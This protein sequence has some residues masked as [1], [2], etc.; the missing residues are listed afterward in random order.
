[1]DRP[2]LTRESRCFVILTGGVLEQ[3]IENRAE[4]IAAGRSATEIAPEDVVRAANEFFEERL[5]DLP[6]L[7]EQAIDRYRQQSSK[8]A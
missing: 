4:E 1:M 8:A 2:R 7:V 3:C 5:S 6:Y